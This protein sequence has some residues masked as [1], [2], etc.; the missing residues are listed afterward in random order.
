MVHTINTKIKFLDTNILLSH[1]DLVEK[2][3][4]FMLSSVTIQE[5]ENIKTNRNKTED[6]KY[7]ARKAVRFL[8]AHPEKYKVILYDSKIQDLYSSKGIINTPDVC[9]IECAMYALKELGYNIDFISNDVL[10]RLIAKENFGITSYGVNDIEEGIY[11]GYL[12][13]KGTA[14]DINHFLVNIDYSTLYANQYLIIENTDDETTKELRFDGE[15]FVN[16]KLPSSQYIKAKNSLQRCALDMLMNPNITIAS[17][18]GSYGSGKSFLTTQMALYHV[19][20]KGNQ[21]K[22]LAVREIRGEGQEIGYLPGDKE[23]K[24]GDFFLPFMQQ[25]HGGEF[26]LENL[27]RRGILDSNIPYFMKGTT[28]NDTIF[29][30]DEAEDLTKKQIRLIGTRL[31]ENSKIF[32]SGDYKQSVVDSSKTN[33]LVEMCNEFKGNKNFGCIYLGEDV[34]SNTSK[35]FAELFTD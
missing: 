4:F 26:E 19:L 8:D 14:D 30:V 15:K 17:I 7:A 3:D 22:I 27:K 25:L 28:Y 5:L 31:G 29:V 23:E 10:S 18:L 6:V 21:S 20:E 32:L 1:L 16:L 13:I 35:M 9:I 33:A 11:K 34:R 24:I 12:T 2:E